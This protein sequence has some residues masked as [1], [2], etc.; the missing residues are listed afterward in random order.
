MN[1][2]QLLTRLKSITH[3]PTLPVIV[4][5]V[6]RLLQDYESP[7]E[8]LVHLLGKDQSMV[9]KILRLVNSSFYGLKSKVN[10]P[11]QAITLMGYNTVRNAIVSV[12]VMDALALKKKLNGFEIEDF[13]KHSIGV[14]IIS[15]YLATKT[16]LVPAEDAFTAGLLHDIG[17]VVLVNFFRDDF[18][19]ITAEANE[20]HLSFFDAELKLNSCTHG[21]V[22]GYLAQQWLLPETL[23]QAIKHHHAGADRFHHSNLSCLVE[24]AN[25]L[26]H[27]LTGDSIYHLRL[28]TYPEDI[29][30]PVSLVLNN[31]GGWFLEVQ[32]EIHAACDFFN[33]GL[34]HG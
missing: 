19:Q 20:N 33:K 23:I 16:S 22:G 34:A 7:M 15:R 18:I 24:L 5:E 14:A 25:S 4:L 3:L 2:N 8:Q 17:K 26:T 10:S 31:G 1:R 13:W 32:K 30:N 11:R 29:K 9:I 12:A 27:I 6:N 28:D 21:L